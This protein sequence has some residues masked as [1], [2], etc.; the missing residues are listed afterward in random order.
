MRLP[1]CWF[2]KT[3]QV[4]LRGIPDIIGSLCGQMFAIELKKDIN[5]D[6]SDLQLHVLQSIADSGGIAMVCCPENWQD[7]L[8][9]LVKLAN[10]YASDRTSKGENVQ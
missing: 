9:I 8:K 4:A 2:Y 3:Q 1:E 7:S 5:E 10:Q 6:P